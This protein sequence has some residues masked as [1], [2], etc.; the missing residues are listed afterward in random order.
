MPIPARVLEEALVPAALPHFREEALVPAALPHF[1]EKALSPAALRLSQEEAQ[2]R[3][4]LIRVQLQRLLRFR[5]DQAQL[6]SG[7]EYKKCRSRKDPGGFFRLS[8]M[9]PL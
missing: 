4:L 1:R 6:L 3:P 9:V 2:A 7:R 8:F 5:A